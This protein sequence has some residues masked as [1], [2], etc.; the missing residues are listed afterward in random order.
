MQNALWRYAQG[1][2]RA[3]RQQEQC[4]AWGQLPAQPREGGNLVLGAGK[5]CCAAFCCLVLLLLI[6]SSF[7]LLVGKDRWGQG[8]GICNKQ[9]GLLINKILQKQLF[10][11]QR[12]GRQ[13]N[14]T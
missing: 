6:E 8:G 11:I 9:D 3:Q 12:N 13:N 4:W 10:S 1:A 5:S 14:Q 2:E 7:S